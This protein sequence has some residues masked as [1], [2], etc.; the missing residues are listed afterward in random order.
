L[1]YEG[2]ATHVEQHAIVDFA[3]GRDVGLGL[4]GSSGGTSTINVGVRIAHFRADTDVAFSYGV[5][6]SGPIS[7]GS[8]SI[9]FPGHIK[10]SFTGI[11]P[12]IA[13][14]GSLPS[15]RNPAFS[16]D[17]GVAG[18][19]LFGRQKTSADVEFLGYSTSVVSERNYT[20]PNVEGFAAVSWQPQNVPGKFTVGYRIDAYFGVIDGGFDE[21]DS[22]D[23]IIHGPFAR[24]TVGLD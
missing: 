11:G 16:F 21:A 5:S 23:R 20:V 10:R 18:A 1:F 12:R 3:V 14:N 7:P 4:L 19:I 22:V 17:W 8:T 6:Y 13:W 24:F 2:R 15:P 9:D